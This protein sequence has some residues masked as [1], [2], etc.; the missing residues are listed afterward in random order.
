MSEDAVT[1]GGDDAPSS[2]NGGEGEPSQKKKAESVCA[3]S[4]QRSLQQ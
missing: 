2:A 3:T 1:G 4:A